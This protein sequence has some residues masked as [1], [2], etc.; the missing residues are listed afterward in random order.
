MSR[1]VAVVFGLL[2]FWWVGLLVKEYGVLITTIV[3]PALPIGASSYAAEI[4]HASL[5]FAIGI[6]CVICVRSPRPIVW[7]ALWG[8]L[9]WGI[10]ALIKWGAWL[11]DQA[12]FWSHLV[13]ELALSNV[14]LIFAILGGLVANAARILLAKRAAL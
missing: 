5:A 12:Y 3:E 11:E 7:A 4:F 1:N 14:I 6:V 2:V 13:S 10:W 8:S 9:M